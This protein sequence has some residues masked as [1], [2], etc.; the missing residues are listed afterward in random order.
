MTVRRFYCS[1]TA[2]L[3]LSSVY[4][5]DGKV[6]Y[7]YWYSL[8]IMGARCGYAHVITTEELRSGQKV[9][10]TRTMSHSAIRRGT[11]TVT[12]DESSEF[13]ESAAGQAICFERTVAMSGTR[14]R[15]SGRVEGD[16]IRI[17]TESAGRIDER[18]FDW[19]P[20]WLFPYAAE[21]KRREYGLKPGTTY[22][23]NAYMPEMNL[24]G[25]TQLK[26]TVIGK[27]IKRVGDNDMQLTR[28]ETQL[29]LQGV[30]MTITEYCDDNFVP[31]IVELPLAQTRMVLTT[32]EQALQT[33]EVAELMA[34]SLIPSNRRINNPD[35]VTSA[36]LKLT[37]TSGSFGD[38]AQDIRQSVR[39]INP[40]QIEVLTRRLGLPERAGYQP[41][42]TEPAMKKYLSDNWL[43]QANNAEIK[44]LAARIIGG[45]KDPLKIARKIDEWIYTNIKQKNLSIALGTAV[46]VA[47]KL[48]GD[49]T[50]HA[51]LAAALFR[52]VGIPSRI[53]VGLAYSPKQNVFGYHMW[54][55]C[56]VGEWIPVDPA[57]PGYG[58]DALHI[59]FEK[60]ALDTANPEMQLGIALIRYFANLKVEVVE[61]KESVA[62]RE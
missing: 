12:A 19:N 15:V 44:R 9:F 6:I 38:F 50:E 54:T 39:R 60:S 7:D 45:E 33:A 34:R 8:Y 35:R 37:L 3:L 1:I 25:P 49:C 55:E 17:K 57:F 62:G 29:L 53:V 47:R 13:V 43:L 59:A 30:Q 41:P 10:V 5:A 2:L 56:Y 36:R 24:T 21:L 42:C 46:D 4:A 16:K 48:E 23:V 52:A 61:V 32:Q 22:T 51:I 58:I 14:M 11:V 31:H 40:S 27:E 28:I 18:L 26:T 20:D